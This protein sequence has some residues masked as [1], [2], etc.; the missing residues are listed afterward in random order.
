MSD[1]LTYYLIDISLNI[2]NKDIL[3]Q[4]KN[5]INDKKLFI[6]EKD[7]PIDDTDLMHGSLIGLCENIRLVNSSHENIIVL[8]Q[9]IFYMY[10]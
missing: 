1:S 9:I 2:P 5:L 10:L 6:S 7:T 8:I 4:I 3:D